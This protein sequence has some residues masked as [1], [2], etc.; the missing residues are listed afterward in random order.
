MDGP[1]RSVN[2]ERAFENLNF[3]R[4]GKKVQDTLVSKPI[5]V[6]SGENWKKVHLHTK[7]DCFY[8]IYRYE[9]NKEIFIMTL[10]QCHVLML[11]EGTALE[12]NVNSQ[13][14]TFQYAETFAVPAAANGYKLINLGNGT[15]KVIVS[16]I[17]EEACEI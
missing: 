17:K 1:S 13:S 7:P 2:I 11:V 15:A 8:T 14:K 5:I 12:L 10:H 9:F 3:E 4:Q 16:L 6:A